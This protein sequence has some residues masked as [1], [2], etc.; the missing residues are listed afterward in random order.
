MNVIAQLEYEL[1]YDDSAVQRFNHYTTRTIIM[2]FLAKYF[3]CS[4]VIFPIF[5]YIYE[6]NPQ[7]IVSSHCLV[8]ASGGPQVWVGW[9]KMAE[10]K[11]KE[12]GCSYV[13]YVVQY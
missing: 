13:C 2:C 3:L 8:Y 9:V 6:G 10:Y 4:N 11:I 1:A 5:I 12:V 7:Q